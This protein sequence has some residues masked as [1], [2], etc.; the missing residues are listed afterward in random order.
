MQSLTQLTQDY[1]KI[2]ELQKN[3]DPKTLKAY[4]IDLRQFC[5]FL[6]ENK[7]APDKDSLS[8]YV[9]AMNQQ[10][11]PRSVKRKIASLKAF[12]RHLEDENLL[13]ENPFHRLRLGI[14]EPV[15]LPRTI[16]LRSI[17]QMLCAAYTRM[18]STHK[19]QQIRVLRDIA[20]MEL[21][22]MTGIRVSELCKLDLSDVDLNDGIIRIH[23]KGSKERILQ[24]GNADVL[25]V[26]ARY[27]SSAI[28]TDPLPFFTNRFGRRLSEQSVRL[29]LRH[30]E[31]ESGQPLHVTPHMFRHSFAT[32][33]L[34]EDVD[35]RYIQ[36]MLGHSSIT[37]TQIYTHVTTSKQKD[38]LLNKHPRNK[39]SI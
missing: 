36:Q 28:R 1:L 5:E 8:Q 27:T 20:V 11:K 13:P 30:Y 10:Y 6:S 24:I 7:F 37:T 23:G 3:L 22:F 4:R 32:L 29:I 34:E 2:C 31:K 38:I 17:E 16:P 35:I 39:V 9:M 21:L 33:L 14:R 18:D 15:Q 26:L 12:F 19:S 25:A